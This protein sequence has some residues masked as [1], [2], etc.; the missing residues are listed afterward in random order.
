MPILHLSL[1]SNL[2]Q[3]EQYLRV[4][5]QQLRLT[6]GLPVAVSDVY[7]TVAWGVEQQPDFLNLV[8]LYDTDVATERVLRTLHKIEAAAGRQ[9]A[10]RWGSRTLDID[11][12]AH[13]ERRIQTEQL[14]V[15]H[16]RLAERNFVLAPWTDVAPDYHPPGQA[17]TVRELFAEGLDPLAVTH[18]GPLELIH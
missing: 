4:A 7:R 11:I 5:L 9:R 15:P 14:T 18:V 13:G 6:Y 8:A 1:G 10:L 17:G 2:G 3:R 16:P 12:L